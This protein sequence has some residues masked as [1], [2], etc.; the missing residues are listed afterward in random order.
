MGVSVVNNDTIIVRDRTRRTTAGLLSVRNLTVHY[1][2]EKR[3]FAAVSNLNFD[4]RPGEIVGV[5][6]ESGCGKTTASLA[7][8]GL[9]PP[10]AKVKCGSVWFCGRDLLLLKEPQLQKIRGAEIALIYQDS[11][12]LNPVIRVGDQVR[13]VLQAHRRCTRDVA[14]EEVGMVFSALGLPECDRLFDAY[15]H[16]LSG[17]QRQRVA[18]AQALICKPRL[19][20]ADEPTASV[21]QETAADILR[22]MAKMRDLTGTSFL[23][24]SHDPV[25]LSSV[26]DRLIVMYAGQIVEQG[27]LADIYSDPLHPYTRALL[28]CVPSHRPASYPV[29]S[30]K[31]RLPFIPGSPPDPLEL[32]SGCSFSSRCADRMLVCDSSKPE[33]TEIAGSRLVRCL[34]YEDQD[35]A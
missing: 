8:L 31:G 35:R 17:G 9:L 25:A 4:I 24:I 15:P 6:G 18:I 5:L 26:A 12:V 33:S 28:Q 29:D 3:E 1:R 30:G 7:I 10:T 21:D 27:A 11:G 16:Q 23:V 14:Q 20:I 13:E 22:F 2:A 34:K 32:I 19:V